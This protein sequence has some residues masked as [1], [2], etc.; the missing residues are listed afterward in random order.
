MNLKSC[1]PEDCGDSKANTSTLVRKNKITRTKNVIMD[2]EDRPSE[3]VHITHHS[4]H[5]LFEDDIEE[6]Y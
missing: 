4:T 1:H 3:S 6:V 5:T 2:V